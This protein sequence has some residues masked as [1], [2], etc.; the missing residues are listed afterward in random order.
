[1][2]V[3]VKNYLVH[4]VVDVDYSITDQ[5]W[6][7]LKCFSNVMFCFC[8]IPPYESEY[9]TNQSFAGIHEKMKDVS[10]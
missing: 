3:L 8:Y 5:V 4:Q 9:F 1:M 10:T 6:M 2:V 7:K